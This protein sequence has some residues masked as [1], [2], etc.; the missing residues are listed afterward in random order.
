MPDSNVLMDSE[1]RKI[2]GISNILRPIPGLK[3]RI[4]GHTALAGTAEGR[5]TL[6]RER[7]Q[8]VA[9]YLISLGGIRAADVIVVYYGADRPIA[10]NQT[11]E[12]MATNRRVEITILED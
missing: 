5:S 12:G 3:I 2:Q 9:D 1:R 10:T 4:G 7:A 6:S 11:P 8:S